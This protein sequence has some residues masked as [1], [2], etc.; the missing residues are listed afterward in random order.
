MKYYLKISRVDYS[1]GAAYAIVFV[2]DRKLR[3]E[4]LKTYRETINNLS[5]KNFIDDQ[6]DL[7]KNIFS[8]F[9]SFFNSKK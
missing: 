4:T 5:C 2:L 3:E 1:L 6:V 8:K 9:S 7:R